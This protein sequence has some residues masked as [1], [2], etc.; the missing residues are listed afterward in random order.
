MP[1]GKGNPKSEFLQIRVTKQ[2]RNRID[3]AA[4]KE[5]LDTS[6][7]ARKVILEAVARLESK[8]GDGNSGTKKN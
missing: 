3:R 1:K 8:L 5:F 7:W 4:S 6:T 2:D